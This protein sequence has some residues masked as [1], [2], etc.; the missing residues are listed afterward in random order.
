MPELNHQTR[1]YVSPLTAIEREGWT[2]FV[3][4]EAPNWI[5]ADARGAWLLQHLMDAPTPFAE[6]VT[7]YGHQFAIDT[8]KAWVH[9][10]A[11]IGEAIG[12]GM[13]TLPR[14]GPPPYLGRAQH[15]SLSRL[16]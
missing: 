7:R 16:R 14:G 11:F 10:Q 4:P 9:V 3:D 2:I 12:Q 6:L 13:V 5:A 1:L 8:A 15:L